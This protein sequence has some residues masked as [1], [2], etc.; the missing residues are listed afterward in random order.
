MALSPIAALPPGEVIE[1]I[2]N[3]E[4]GW[5]PHWAESRSPATAD[6]ENT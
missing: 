4:T 3:P 5:G 1:Q 2:T 6:G